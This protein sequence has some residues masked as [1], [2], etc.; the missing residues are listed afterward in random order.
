MKLLSFFIATGF[1]S[2]CL[3]AEP[4]GTVILQDDFNREE[5]DPQLEE[6]GNDWG[7]NSRSRAKGVKQVNLVDGAM[8]IT[9]A[10]VADHGVSVTHE[11]E[12]KDAIIQLRFKI[13]PQDDFGVDIADM[14]EK[15]VHAGH[16]SV[17]RI[18]PQQVEI[19]D[20]KTGRMNLQLRERR[21][22][23]KQTEADKKT[24]NTTSKYIKHELSTDEWHQ[25]EM[26]NLGDTMVVVLDGQEVG[27]HQSIGFGHPTKTRIRLAVN[28]SAWVDDVKVVRLN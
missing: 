5:S 21:L 24:V 8:H 17:V 9:R 2:L 27:R 16:I 26:R 22:A 14:N 10:D 18:R 23:Q 4:A 19:S 20:L 3:A 13:G 6:I 15:S 25:L 1:C 28:K 7:T 12:F 11:A